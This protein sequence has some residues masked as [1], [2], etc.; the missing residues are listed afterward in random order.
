MSFIDELVFSPNIPCKVHKMNNR[1]WLNG[2]EL[3][4]KSKIPYNKFIDDIGKCEER[5]LNKGYSLEEIRKDFFYYYL[6][7]DY[8]VITFLTLKGCETLIVGKRSNKYI[9]FKA[10]Y[11]EAFELNSI[12]PPKMY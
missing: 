7:D 11:K 12:V 3:A 10:L 2:Y 5:L 9:T 8:N 4:K 1:D 6:D